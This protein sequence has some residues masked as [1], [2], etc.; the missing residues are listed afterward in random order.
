MRRVWQCWGDNDGGQLG[1]G[2]TLDRGDNEFEMG[3]DLAF[4]DLGEGVNATSIAVG[5]KHACAVVGDG[6]VK[7]W[8]ER[9]E[10]FPT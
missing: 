2:D 10:R 7:C 4:V 1:L 5:S 8:G 9:I 6:D 3:D